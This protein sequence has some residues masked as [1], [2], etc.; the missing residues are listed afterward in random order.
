MAAQLQAVAAAPW[1]SMGITVPVEP[2]KSLHRQSFWQQRGPFTKATAHVKPLAQ[3]L[4]LGS[5]TLREV[6]G[7]SVSSEHEAVQSASVGG[8]GMLVAVGVETG[9]RHIPVEQPEL[10]L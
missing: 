10:M 2:R 8:M 5:E 4:S 7:Q 3:R 6:P 1:H 9:L